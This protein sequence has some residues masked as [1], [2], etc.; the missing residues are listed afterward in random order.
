MLFLAVLGC[1]EPHNP[2]SLPG[3][4]GRSVRLEICKKSRDRSHPDASFTVTEPRRV[5]A[6]VGVFR[7][8]IRQTDHKCADIGRVTI[9][10]ADGQSVNLE[11]LPGHRSANYEFRYQRETY[12]VPRDALFAALEEAGVDTEAIPKDC[13]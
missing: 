9:T 13:M 2:V 12:W 8:G 4:P 11:I 6:I 1:S 5:D 7:Q 3:G 10:F